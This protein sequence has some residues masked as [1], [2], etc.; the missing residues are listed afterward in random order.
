MK[1]TT[2]PGYF[3]LTESAGWQ[4]CPQLGAVRISGLDHRSW[5]QAQI[6]QDVEAQACFSACFCSISGQMEA[7]ARC[8]RFPDSLVIVAEHPDLE[9]VEERVSQYVV[10]EDVRFEWI[11]QPV[12]T[13]QGPNSGDLFPHEPLNEPRERS[14]GIVIPHS[15]TGQVG[16]DLIGT[17]WE[18]FLNPEKKATS[19][20]FLVAR[21]EILTAAR[22]DILEKVFPAEMGA[23]FERSVMSYSKGCYLGQEVLMRLHARGHTN[24]L[25]MPIVLATQAQPHDRIVDGQGKEVGTLT[26]VALSPRF[27][28]IGAA[29]MQLKAVEITL[30]F[31]TE[32]GVALTVRKEP[33]V[34]L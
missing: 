14:E 12:F 22:S 7:L 24:R 5:L 17:A 29:L 2:T 28:W 23:C 4:E 10:L 6:T 34:V 25:W 13:L 15:R 16:F 31:R 3:L 27:G 26:S 30:D 33:W 20:D 9:V 11:E 8:A 21:L 19:E 18:T 1:E 32:T